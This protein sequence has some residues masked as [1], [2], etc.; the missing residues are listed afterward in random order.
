MSNLSQLAVLG[1]LVGDAAALGLHWIYSDAVL[2]A[3][4]A[5]PSL[6]FTSPRETQTFYRKRPSVY[7]H[8]HKSAGDLSPYGSLLRMAVQQAALD[9]QVWSDQSVRVFKRALVEAFG[10]GGTYVGYVDATI[11][12]TLEAVLLELRLALDA[13]RV[14]DEIDARTARLIRHVKVF[15]LALV[16]DGE[17]LLNRSLAATRAS[18]NFDAALAFTKD[19]VAAAEAV[20]AAAQ[21]CGQ[22]DVAHN[23]VA[24]RSLLA[25]VL[26]LQLDAQAAG[27]AVR[28]FNRAV[29]QADDSFAWCD[30]IHQLLRAVLVGAT[31]ADAIAQLDVGESAAVAAAVGRARAE[32][33]TDHRDFVGSVGR[34][35]YLSCS[36]PAVLHLLLQV[37]SRQLEPTAAFVWALEQ[38][39]LAGGDSCGR[40]ALVGSILGAA[41]GDVPAALLDQLADRATLLRETASL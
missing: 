36:V 32:V 30:V 15:P 28:R 34:A 40:A 41:H 24:V 7:A 3:Q 17:E 21:P 10:P 23:T 31:I 27:A 6:L 9:R 18:H 38:C 39:V 13:V 5:L 11:R 20:R 19:V 16:C 25:T 22:A 35:S 26:T 4:A 1:A 2:D 12:L 14:P 33:A 29:T 37:S 8:Q